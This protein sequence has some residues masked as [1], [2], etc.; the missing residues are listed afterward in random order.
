MKKVVP[1]ISLIGG[2]LLLYLGYDQY[3]SLPSETEPFFG[4]SGQYQGLWMIVVG[5]AAAIAGFAGLFRDK[6]E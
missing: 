3:H 6:L 5:A 4:V 1:V 2:L